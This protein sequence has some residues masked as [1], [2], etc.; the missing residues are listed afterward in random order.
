MIKHA[1]SLLCRKT[2][3]DKETNN[4]SIIDILEQVQVNASVPS[5]A[6]FPVKVPISYELVSMWTREHASDETKAEIEIKITG[7]DGIVG[8]TH[9]KELVFPVSIQRMRSRIRISGIEIT[10]SGVYEFTVGIK[11]EKSHS[12]TTVATIPLSVILNK[13]LPKSVN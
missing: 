3:I 7:P 5:N 1:W 4:L 10:N 8:T 13:N 9:S 6:V 2:I 12:F 11:E